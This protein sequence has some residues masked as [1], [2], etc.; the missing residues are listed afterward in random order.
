MGRKES[1]R[2]EKCDDV[3]VLKD[4]DIGTDWII[5]ESRLGSSVAYVGLG[6]LMDGVLATDKSSDDECNDS[7]A[8]ILNSEV[9]YCD[10]MVVPSVGIGST[11]LWLV[12]NV[13]TDRLWE[14]IFTDNDMVRNI[15]TNMCWSMTVSIFTWSLLVI[16]SNY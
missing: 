5:G 3:E 8:A 16:S 15:R 10:S 11:I 4:R 13:D 7:E 1:I 9:M 6:W 14:S 12:V 2:D